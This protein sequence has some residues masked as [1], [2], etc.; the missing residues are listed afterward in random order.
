MKCSILYETR[1]ETERVGMQVGANCSAD[2]KERRYHVKTS[3][4]AFNDTCD[5]EQIKDLSIMLE[6]I[7]SN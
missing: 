3:S 6:G 7:D 1:L 2:V 5:N 4:I